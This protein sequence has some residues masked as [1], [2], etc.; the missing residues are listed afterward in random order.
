MAVFNSKLKANVYITVEETADWLGISDEN[1]EVPQAEVKS[2][3][4]IQDLTYTAKAVGVLGDAV[5]I[6]YVDGAAAVGVI[7]DAITVTFPTGALDPN[8]EP[9]SQTAAGMGTG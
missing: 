6:E 5:S 8:A 1:I 2:S 7:S 3:L 4:I 9:N